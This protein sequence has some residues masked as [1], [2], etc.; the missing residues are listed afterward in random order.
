MS[1][2]GRAMAFEMLRQAEP[3]NHLLDCP[4][5]VVIEGDSAPERPAA[6]GNRM[7][8]VLAIQ[9]GHGHAAAKLTIHALVTTPEEDG[10]G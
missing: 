1:D 9:C 4:D 10:R 2:S 8:M 6:E 5:A 3:D 7:T